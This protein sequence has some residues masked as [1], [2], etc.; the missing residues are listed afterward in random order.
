MNEKHFLKY[1]EKYILSSNKLGMTSISTM[2]EIKKS[3]YTPGSRCEL[4][5]PVSNIL[6]SPQTDVTNA[7]LKQIPLNVC[8]DKSSEEQLFQGRNGS[9]G[10]LPRMGPSW[11]CCFPL[12][13]LMIFSETAIHSIKARSCSYFVFSLSKFSFN[14]KEVGIFK[15]ELY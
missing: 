5:V 7:N 3:K 12:G 4:C 14:L 13:S 9:A 1:L 10:G 11:N 8:G 6:F 2:E 15:G